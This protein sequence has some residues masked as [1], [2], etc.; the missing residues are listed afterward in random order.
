[1]SLPAALPVDA[2]GTYYLILHD[3]FDDERAYEAFSVIVR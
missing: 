3:D 1:M 2:A